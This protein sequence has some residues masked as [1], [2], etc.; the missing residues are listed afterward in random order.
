[1]R[2]KQEVAPLEQQ[3]IVQ[4]NYVEEERLRLQNFLQK[5]QKEP[6]VIEKTPDGRANTVP[7]SHI[8]MTLDEL[9]FGMWS[10]ENFKWQ[11]ISNE[12]VGSLELVVTNPV[13]NT[14]I[15]RIGSASIQIMVDAIPQEIKQDREKAKQ[16]QLDAQNKKA[17]ALD[18]GFPKLKAECLKNASQSLGKVFGRDINRKTSDTFQPLVKKKLEIKDQWTIE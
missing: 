2:K 8:E 12:I 14:Q 6:S 4:L 9:Y 13:N 7:I 11:V 10:T 15:R 17:N 1:M 3:P 18:M 16:W 5:L